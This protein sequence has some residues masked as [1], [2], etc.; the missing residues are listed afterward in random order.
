MG[1]TIR[2]LKQFTVVGGNGTIFKAG[3]KF[4]VE[5]YYEPTRGERMWSKLTYPFR[6]LR[7]HTF[8]IQFYFSNLWDA[9][10]GR[11]DGF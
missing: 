5:G 8:G 3:D 9:I 2:C 7:W 4:T 1:K 6:W 11:R 10:C